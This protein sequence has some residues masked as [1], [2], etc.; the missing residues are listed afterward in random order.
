MNTALYFLNYYLTYQ[1]HYHCCGHQH[2]L[3]VYC[4]QV[5]WPMKLRIAQGVIR[6]MKYLHTRTP[7]VVHGDLKIQN[8]LI[9]HDYEAKVSIGLLT[10]YI[11]CFKN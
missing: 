4:I 3:L 7:P 1:Y 5:E 8:V 2:Q 6:G 9:G 11:V 10:N